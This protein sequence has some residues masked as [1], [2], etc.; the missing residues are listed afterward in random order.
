MTMP[1]NKAHW[2]PTALSFRVVHMI[3]VPAYQASLELA[4]GRRAV[5]QWR[6]SVADRARCSLNRI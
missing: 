4:L 1:P 3:T 5:A 2:R 6:R